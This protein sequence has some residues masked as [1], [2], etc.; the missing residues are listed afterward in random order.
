[1]F[2]VFTSIA[3]RF[4]P[5]R[6]L[7]QGFFSPRTAPSTHAHTAPA[8]P[9]HATP[10][11]TGMRYSGSEF[12]APESGSEGSSDDPRVGAGEVWSLG[13][14]GDDEESQAEEAGYRDEVP[15]GDEDLVYEDDPAYES[16]YEDVPVRDEL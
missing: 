2:I 9:A 1:M 14:A 8:H 4:V 6:T 5:Y 7:A 16:A 15:G 10:K 11:L 3:H 12:D 13:A